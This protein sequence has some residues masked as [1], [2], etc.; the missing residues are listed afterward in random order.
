[1]PYK[2]GSLSRGQRAFA[3]E[4]A[5]NG[6]DQA[7]AEKKAKLAKNSGYAI[8]RVPEVQ[9]EIHKTQK[10]AMV[11]LL[12]IA[13]ETILKNMKSNNAAVSEKAA[14]FVWNTLHIRSES[15][16]HSMMDAVGGRRVR[17]DGEPFPPE[18]FAQCR[19]LPAE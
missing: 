16:L 14:E 7:K 4:F 8:L 17:E 19:Q 10:A 18:A 11:G 5:T 12:P 9:L 2:D 6:G 1:M 15:Q 13:T 3:L